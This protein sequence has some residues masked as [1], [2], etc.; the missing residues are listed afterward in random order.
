MLG[1]ETNTNSKDFD[2]ES[3]FEI[4]DYFYFYDLKRLD[5]RAE[6]EVK[7]LIKHLELKPPMKILDLACGHGRHANKLASKGFA[8]TGVD[9]SKDFIEFAKNEARKLGISVKYMIKDIRKMDFNEE[10]DRIINMF[11]SF[12]YFSDHENFL[13]LKNIAR[14]LKTGGLFCLD[15]PNIHNLVKNLREYLV[16]EKGND[17]MIDRNSFDPITCRWYDNR[18]VIRDGKIKRKP[19]FVRIYTY[20][21]IKDLLHK[22]GL[23]IKNVFGDFSGKEFT[24][25]S[26]RMIII[27]KKT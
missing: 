14:A 7:F 17:I 13:I 20:P 2:F 18:L 21:E 19:F 4:N 25:D 9:I 15:L 5:E 11:T 22:T 26:P 3:V 10:F 23:I 27:A 8:V 12:G 6:I 24:L 16:T 1:N